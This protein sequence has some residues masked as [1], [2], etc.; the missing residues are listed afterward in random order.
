MEMG[1]APTVFLRQRE[2]SRRILVLELRTELHLSMKSVAS[3]VKLPLLLMPSYY[4]Y[5]H[6]H[7]LAHT[8]GRTTV[9]RA[10]KATTRLGSTDEHRDVIIGARLK[11]AVAKHWGETKVA[12]TQ[13]ERSS[14]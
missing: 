1:K 2:G 10:R 9:H 3:R 4:K 12:A 5:L 13:G 11:A 8:H 14:E 7:E 6:R